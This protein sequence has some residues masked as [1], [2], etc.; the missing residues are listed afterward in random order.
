MSDIIG[1]S[2]DGPVA[3]ANNDNPS[4]AVNGDFMHEV[5]EATDRARETFANIGDS[6]IMVAMLNFIADR[7]G[8]SVA[9]ARACIAAL[10][11]VGPPDPRELD[12]YGLGPPSCD[13]AHRWPPPGGVIEGGD[14]HE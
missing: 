12:R 11:L 2:R 5:A 9:D 4:T 7:R 13:P 1:V 10:P 14:W 6:A 8:C 3:I